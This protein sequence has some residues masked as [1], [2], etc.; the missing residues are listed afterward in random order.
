MFKTREGLYEW[1]FMPFGLTGAPSTFM[2]LMNTILKSLIGRYV[3]VYL[4]DIFEY[5]TRPAGHLTREP[6]LY[7]FFIVNIPAV[8]IIFN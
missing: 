5:P 6:P 4:N 3:V 2:R 1:R 8:F 7:V